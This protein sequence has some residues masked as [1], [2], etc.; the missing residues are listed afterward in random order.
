MDQKR[1][2]TKVLTTFFRDYIIAENLSKSTV[3]NYTSDLEHFMGW[4]GLKIGSVAVIS[5]KD[6]YL[7]ENLF[8]LISEYKKYLLYQNTT[9]ST[10]LRRMSSL[11]KFSQICKELRLIDKGIYERILV[12]TQEKKPNLRSWTELI[13]SFKKEN[14]NTFDKESLFDIANTS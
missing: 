12:L 14:P 5:N 6:K 13:S 11:R 7:L 1:Y 8:Q 9:I 2:N 3:L 10:F 4:V